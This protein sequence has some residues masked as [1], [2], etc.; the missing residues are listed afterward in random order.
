MDNRR[1]G[2][3]T[4][5]G[6]MAMLITIIAIAGYAFA[7]GGLLYN[8]G[9]LNAQPGEMLGGVTSHAEIDGQ[10]QACHTAPWSAQNMSDRCVACHG[11]IARQ[12]QSMVALH[13]AMYATNPRLVCR[14]CHP[15]HKGTDA[16]LT[17]MHEGEFP[18]ELLG[19]SLNGHRQTVRGDAFVCSDCH[20][21]DIT[22]FAPDSCQACHRQMDAA[23]AGAH[24]LSYGA[25]CLAC[26]DGVD[27]LGRGFRHNVYEFKLT[28]QHAEI[29]CVDCHRGARRM[30][31]LQSAPQNCSACHFDDDAHLA[32]FGQACEQ[33]HSTDGWKP[34]RFD[35]NLSVFKL[36]GEHAEAAC[37][38]CHQG[39]VYQG[40]PADCYACH[41]K[42]DEH[43][44]SFGTD[45]AACHTPAGWDETTFDHNLSKFPLDGA[46]VSLA[47]EKCHTI[48]QFAGLSTACVSCHVDPAFHAGVLGTNCADCHSTASWFPARFNVS[49]PRPRVE[50]EGTG[51]NHGNTSCRTCHPSTVRSYTCLACHSDNNGG[52]GGGGDDDD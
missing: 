9:P 49:H 43:N 52:E 1:L 23:F 48:G 47:C 25:D 34:A 3:L 8:P 24:E 16:P 10:C 7:R 17:V 6:I 2:C 13:G 31:D 35:H 21:D 11:E 50:E 15:D 42:D 28:G 40:T 4:P 12:M 27:T 20:A 39:G 41:Q 36:E 33:C 29:V 14:D 45:C 32:R 46:H 37:E 38:D 22:T 44:G 5:V 26:H 19:F 30:A 18:H 51:V